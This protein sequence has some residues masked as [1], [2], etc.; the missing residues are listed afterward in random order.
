MELPVDLLPEILSFIAKPAHLASTCLVNNT[1]HNFSVRLL[2]DR[3]AIYSWHENGKKRAIKLF[4]T[5]ACYP[6]LARLVHHLEIRDFP[7][8][9]HYPRVVNALQLC[10]NLRSCIW[11]RDG[12]LTSDIL[13][14]LSSCPELRELEING[15]SDGIYDH[16]LLLR[17]RNL[18]KL[19]IIMP[20][21]TVVS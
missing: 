8:H 5:L 4:T 21:E 6:E 14:A 18:N 16:T 7:K 17:F 10:T 2:Y 15:H 12:T 1:F 13:Q 20:C 11:T 19:S 9:Y 3:I